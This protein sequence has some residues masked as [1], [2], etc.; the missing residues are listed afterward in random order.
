MI[1][2]VRIPLRVVGKGK[3]EG[4]SPLSFA[5]SDTPSGVPLGWVPWSQDRSD[6]HAKTFLPRDNHHGKEEKG[7]W[8]APESL[9]EEMPDH[10]NDHG[11]K[12][13]PGRSLDNG[14]CPVW[15]P[16]PSCE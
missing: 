13:V 7:T 10:G 9:T 12:R 11:N 5:D 16:S 6:R 8:H 3:M 15:N 4:W 14:K 1:E 2:V